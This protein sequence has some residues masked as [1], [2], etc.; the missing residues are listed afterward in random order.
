MD[1]NMVTHHKLLIT[2]GIVGG[3][4]WRFYNGAQTMVDQFIASAES[5]WQRS[6]RLVMLL[7]HGC[8]MG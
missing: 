8:A 3:A 2:P 7:P 6:E 4:V 5:K 1:L